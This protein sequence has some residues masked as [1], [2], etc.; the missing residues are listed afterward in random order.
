VVA[1][2][3]KTTIVAVLM[4]ISPVLFAADTPEPLFTSGLGWQPGEACTYAANHS[5]K[6]A[7]WKFE[8]NEVT[9]DLT[10]ATWTQIS[11]NTGVT[12]PVV[13][14]ENGLKFTS[15]LAWVH[16][17]AITSE[18]GY[19]WVVFPLEPKSEWTTEAVMAGVNSKNG[20]PFKV[21]VSASF[22]A[23]KWEK[24]KTAVGETMALRVDAKERYVGIDANYAGSG[25]YTIWLGHG[26]CSL[27][28]AQYSNSFSE[29]ASLEL[30]S[31]S[32]P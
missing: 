5:G 21:K 27:K 30:V 10:K 22:N 19:Q 1:R 23:R 28:K 8:V 12:V 3:I 4:L 7:E 6:K 13:K 2:Q 29:R 15:D 26:A 14:T 20:K 11:P 9:G 32:A 31:E 24:I 17:N 18:P 25:S 16:G